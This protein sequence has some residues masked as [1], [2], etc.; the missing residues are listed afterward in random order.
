M[1]SLSFYKVVSS[2]MN[3]FNETYY[4]YEK[5]TTYLSVVMKY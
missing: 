1:S 3:L 2:T 5:E 4:S